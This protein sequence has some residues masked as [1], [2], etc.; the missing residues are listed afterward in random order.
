MLSNDGGLARD[1]ARSLMTARTLHGPRPGSSMRAIL[2]ALEARHIPIVQLDERK[3]PLY[4]LGHGI[5]QRRL[6]TTTSSIEPYLAVDAALDKA[7]TLRILDAAGIPVPRSIV[8]SGPD[9]AVAAA[10]R[11]GYPVV[12]K[13]RNG[14]K[15]AGVAIVR[16]SAQQVRTAYD[17]ACRIDAQGAVLIEEEVPGVSY[18]VLVIDGKAVGV[19]ERYPAHVVGDGEHDIR[20]LI[21][22]ENDEMR[23]SDRPGD[24]VA[25]LA[26]DA[27][28]EECL[29]AQGLSA[30]DVPAAGQEVRL[31]WLPG[32]AGGG[33]VNDRTDDAHPDTLFLAELATRIMGLDVAGIDLMAPDIS[34]SPSQGRVA[35][36]EVNSSPS[37]RGN[38]YPSAGTPRD[39]F[40]TYIDHLF[41]S[42]SDG[43]VPIIGVQASTDDHTLTH[44][45]GG[46]L[47]AA[48]RR[49]GSV[50]ADGLM[51]TDRWLRHEDMRGQGGAGL[52]L[53]NPLVDTALVEATSDG[54]TGS[55]ERY[56]QPDVAVIYTLGPDTKRAVET[57]IDAVAADG[58]VV[59]AAGLTDAVVDRVGGRSLV[60]V[61]PPGASATTIASGHAHRRRGGAV[62]T[63]DEGGTEAAIDIH[64]GT[65]T[66]RLVLTAAVSDVLAGSVAGWSSI[67]LGVAV[68]VA[69]GLGPEV[70]RAALSTVAPRSR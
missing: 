36:L 42:G 34:V 19:E 24:L 13:P 40:K 51:V 5:H 68:L 65:G 14:M 1:R 20:G 6:R 48:G 50:S 56:D 46:L 63:V 41:P 7:L 18:R 8:V 12:V 58:T 17:E 15:G 49:V 37:L 35:I 11:I 22:I 54:V 32:Q 70:I 16:G 66:E 43:R 10:E 55:G 30:T 52:V 27:T 39:V 23:H 2:D 25:T 21:A 62:V 44:L 3:R 64:T 67:L 69:I 4:Q 57:L 31:S 33:W 38:L 60:V 29:E 45:I 53:R 26:L 9:E 47:S 59:T 61:V 28:A